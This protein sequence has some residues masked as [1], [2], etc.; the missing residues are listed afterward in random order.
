MDI[1]IY[2]TSF[3]VAVRILVLI[4]RFDRCLDIQE[5]ITYDYLML[6]LA[7]INK[8]CT[9]LHPDNPFHSIELY[10]RRKLV[11]DAVVLLASKGLL[12]SDCNI[13][14]ISYRPTGIS[15]KFLEYFESNYFNKLMENAN[16]LNE[17]YSRMSITDINNLIN[18]KYES[19][20]NKFDYEALFKGEDN[21]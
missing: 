1:K 9:S 13:N 14:G 19:T 17:K 15:N 3:E 16:V 12:L 6:H 10:S 7:D 8:K 2:N 5:I 4:T 20:K 18:Q 21:E 11:Q